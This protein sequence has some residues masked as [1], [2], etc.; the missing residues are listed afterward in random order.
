L[1]ASISIKPTIAFN[2][3]DTFVFESWV[4]TVDGAGSFQRRL[5]M[6]PNPSTGLV[7]LPEVITGELAGKFGE[8]SLYNQHADFEFGSASNSNS[9]SPWV[10]ACE[11]ATEPSC[12]DFPLHEHFPYGLCNA[13]KAHAKALTACRAGKEIVYDYTS[14][15]NCVPSRQGDRLRLHLGLQPRLRLI[16]G[17]FL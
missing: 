8:I 5:T 14:D 10:I 3:G 15:S 2:R 11:L 13:S 1:T 17:L 9:T 4:C 16:L 7:T 12:A 6:A